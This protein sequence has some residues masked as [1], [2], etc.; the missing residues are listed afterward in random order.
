MHCDRSSSPSAAVV[1]S[2]LERALLAEAPNA[3]A[4]S[5][6][7]VG[8]V[9]G[10][11]AA[12]VTGVFV[13]LDATA[14]AC[15]R[16]RSLGANA[17]VTHHPPFLETPERIVP[18]P[19]PEGT[20]T[21]AITSAVSVIAMHTNLDRHPDGA[22]ALAFRLGLEPGAPLEPAP[23]DPARP[24]ARLGTVARWKAGGTV[25][26]LAR[27]AATVLGSGVRIWGEAGRQVRTVAVAN[28]SGG[29]LIEAALAVADV[30]VT[31]EVRYHDAI[32][33]T[34]RGLSIIELG[35]DVSEWPIVSV[36]ADLV[37]Q[38]VPDDVPVHLEQPTSAADTVEVRD[39]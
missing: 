3:W 10:D 35:H 17:L 36:L 6:D 24:E 14:E 34:A 19:G 4:E 23:V 38:S 26:E 33:A 11:P 8:L 30:Y 28:G 1:V 20:L 12:A 9:V 7:R 27:H 22:S 37:R 21:A 15:V 5:W 31:G 2:A 13:T 29:S 16:A 18:G 39:E 32:A 25:A